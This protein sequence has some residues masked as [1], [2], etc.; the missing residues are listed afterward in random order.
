[1]RRARAL[2]PADEGYPAALRDA[3]VGAPTLWVAGEI[4][5]RCVAVVGTRRPDLGGL[6]A[7]RELGRGLAEAGW[8]VVSGGAVGCDAEAHLGALE[9]GGKTVVVL[10]S[11][12]LKP[13]PRENLE[14]MLRAARFYK[15]RM[16][17]PVFGLIAGRSAPPGRRMGHAG[18]IIEGGSGTHASK[19]KALREAGITVIENLSEIGVTVAKALKQK[20]SV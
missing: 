2:Q 11:G 3:A 20:A 12:L 13:Y 8:A 19:V 18:A 1:M 4:P 15:E 7:A 5:E 14:L 17:K 6:R 10:G 9:A 16:S